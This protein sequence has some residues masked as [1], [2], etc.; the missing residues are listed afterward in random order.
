MSVPL[1]CIVVSAVATVAIIPIIITNAVIFF[2]IDFINFFLQFSKFAYLFQVSFQTTP[3]EPPPY[4]F[5]SIIHNRFYFVNV[6]YF[7]LLNLSVKYINV[8]LFFIFSQKHL[9]IFNF[10]YIITQHIN[11]GR[12]MTHQ[13]KRFS[14][15]L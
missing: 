7:S 8:F 1:G 4:S 10:I 15:C 13:Q 11:I 12:M 14:L 6:F 5:N 3:T 9:P 2:Q